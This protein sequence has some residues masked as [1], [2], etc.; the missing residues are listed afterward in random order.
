MNSDVALSRDTKIGEFN[1]RAG[2]SLRVN[3][4]GLH[5]NSSEWQRPTEFLPQRFDPDDPLFLTPNGN[6]RHSDSFVP[7]N[8]GKRI[9]FGKTFAEIVVKIATLYMV[10]L[11]NIEHLSEEKDKYPLMHI[12]MVGDQE[13]LLKLTKYN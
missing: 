7:F 10:E 11:F 8:G 9:C 6:K 13:I 2:D 1:I 5:Y 3:I 4:H 12:G